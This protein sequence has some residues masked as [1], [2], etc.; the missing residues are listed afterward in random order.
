MPYAYIH[1]L[2]YLINK[3]ASFL[4]MV[5]TSQTTRFFESVLDYLV[6]VFLCIIVHTCVRNLLLLAPGDFKEYL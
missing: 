2:L 6:D 4:H 1:L 5:T 3:T